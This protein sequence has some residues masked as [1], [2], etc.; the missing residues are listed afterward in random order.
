MVTGECVWGDQWPCRPVMQQ[1]LVVQRLPGGMHSGSGAALGQQ[2]PMV[3]AEWVWGDQWPCRPAMQQDPGSAACLLG[4]AGW[5]MTGG[6][7]HC[8][9]HACVEPGRSSRALTSMLVLHKPKTQAPSSA[10]SWQDWQ[11][12]KVRPRRTKLV[13][14]SSWASRSSSCGAF[15]ITLRQVQRHTRHVHIKADVHTRVMPCFASAFLA[16]AGHALLAKVIS[17]I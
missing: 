9:C 4:T 5:Q 10:D 3:T 6:R 17:F 15:F 13:R 7:Q 1:H 12:E 8:G 2:T 11:V 14:G 16:S